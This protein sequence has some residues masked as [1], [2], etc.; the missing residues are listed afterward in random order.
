M[1]NKETILETAEN[2]FHANGFA[3]TSV[4]SIIKQSSV[5][6][7]NF[8]YHFNSKE[9]LGLTILNNLVIK[10]ENEVITQTLLNETYNPEQRLT[11]FFEKIVNYHEGL[12]C[13]KGCPFGN[14]AIEQSDTN[15]KFRSKLS[16]FFDDWKNAIEN[17]VSDGIKE[18]YF[19]DEIDTSSL[20]DLILSQIEGA[21]LLSKTHKSIAPLKNSCNQILNLIKKKEKDY[22]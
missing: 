6:K 1:N 17:C 11:M 2:L 8:Y 12:K 7:S 15:E 22:E 10:Y 9:I 20:A 16:K 21:I 18:Y 4:D 19:T 5:S 13:Y 3:K 14:L